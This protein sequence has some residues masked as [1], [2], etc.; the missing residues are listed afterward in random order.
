[1]KRKRGL[2][3]RRACVSPGC[4]VAISNVELTEQLGDRHAMMRRDVF[5]DLVHRADLDGPMIG[6]RHM[7][8]A[9]SQGSHNDMRA[10]L[11]ADAV[12]K[13]PQRPH[14]FRSRAVAR[15]FHSASTSSRTKCNR[16]ILGREAGSAK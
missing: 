15:D 2:N 1:M 4:Q 10:G 11:P 6:N 13:S 9:V 7:V 8:L 12:V 3:R 16:M 5:E 14:Q